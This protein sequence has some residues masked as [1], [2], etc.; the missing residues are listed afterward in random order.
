MTALISGI[1]QAVFLRQDQTPSKTTWLGV[2][3]LQIPRRRPHLLTVVMMR[4]RNSKKRMIKSLRWDARKILMCP[5]CVNNVFGCYRLE[6]LND[7]NAKR[8]VHPSLALH[9]ECS[10][11]DFSVGH[12]KASSLLLKL[13]QQNSLSY[14][15][16]KPH[17]RAK[18][19]REGKSL[20]QTR[21]KLTWESVLSLLLTIKAR[22]KDI[23]QLL[24]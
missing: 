17:W 16:A 12:V 18:R 3:V 13:L 10:G 11:S 14:S 21:L 7:W 4:Q 5:H 20:T 22:R 1:N 2:S 24:V 15:W 8:T 6:W 9:A 23:F 19:T